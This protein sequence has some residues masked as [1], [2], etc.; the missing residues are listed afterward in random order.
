MS[1]VSRGQIQDI[2]VEFAA[3]DPKYKQAL[4]KNPKKILAAQMNQKLPDSLQVKVVE[5]TPDTVHLVLPYKGKG[6]ELSDADLEAVAGGAG[7]GTADSTRSTT[8]SRDETSNTYICNDAQGVG[9]RIEIS[10]STVE[11][12]T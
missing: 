1:D 11:S 2:I 6:G 12:L 4:Q 8:T 7:K 3:K 9:T 10:A 5:D